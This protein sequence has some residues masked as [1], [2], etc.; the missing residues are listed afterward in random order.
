MKKLKIIKSFIST[1]SYE[2]FLE[3][4]FKLT[5]NEA[6]SYICIANVH[7]TIEAYND[8]NFEAIVNDSSITT[9]DG[10]PLAKTIKYLIK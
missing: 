7:M 3:N 6:S 4:I 9:P 2:D 1:G 8:K 5:L 10:M